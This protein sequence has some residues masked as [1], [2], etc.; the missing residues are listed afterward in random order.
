[1]RE[2]ILKPGEIITEV[3]IPIS[4]EGTKSGYIKVKERSAWDFAM[5]SVAAVMKQSGSAITSGK[6]AFGGVAPVPWSDSNINK[7]LQNFSINQENIQRLS[8][9]V[10]T[11]ANPLEKNEYKVIMARN[12]TQRIM[13]QLTMV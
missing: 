7:R 8:R 6:L 1:M 9:E 11:D 13:E 5:V 12:I 10:L 3:R 2:N 4:Q